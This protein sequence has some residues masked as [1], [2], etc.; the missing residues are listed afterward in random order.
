MRARESGVGSAAEGACLRIEAA[1]G[2]GEVGGKCRRVHFFM[3]CLAWSGFG[4]D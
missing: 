4:S 2:V 3:S 1:G